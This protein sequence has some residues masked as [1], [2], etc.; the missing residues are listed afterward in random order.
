M[1]A[2][3]ARKFLEQHEIRFVLAQ[4]VESGSVTVTFV[5]VTGPVFVTVIVKVAV[6]PESTAWVAGVFVIAIAP[7]R[8][9]VIVQ[10][11]FWPAASVIEPL[12]AQSPATVGV[13]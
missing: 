4:F 2:V 8:L 1:T 9:F 7:L 6:P 13:K 12:A 11:A 5:S 10:T 3:E